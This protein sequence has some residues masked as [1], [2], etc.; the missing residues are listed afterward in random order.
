[1]W[2]W[3]NVATIVLGLS[4]GSFGVWSD[5][6]GVMGGSTDPDLKSFS[7]WANGKGYRLNYTQSRA[8]LFGV[9]KEA[10]LWRPSEDDFVDVLKL[11]IQKIT[12]IV[13]EILPA[14]R[15][16]ENE[17]QET[18]FKEMFK[19]AARNWGQSDNFHKVLRRRSHWL[20]IRRTFLD[21][22][23]LEVP[24]EPPD[25]LL[26]GSEGLDSEEE[27]EVPVRKKPR[28]NAS[29]ASSSTPRG[30]KR[31]S[32]ETPPEAKRNRTSNVSSGGR[33]SLWLTA[34]SSDWKVS[35][36]LGLQTLLF[37]YL[38]LHP[39]M[40]V[41]GGAFMFAA[42]GF[43]RTQSIEA[44]V[45]LHALAGGL[46]AM[47]LALGETLE[48]V[49]GNLLWVSL[50]G[51]FLFTCG[52]ALWE[53]SGFFAETSWS[54][55]LETHLAVGVLPA[56]PRQPLHLRLLPFRLPP[57]ALLLRR[58]LQPQK[59]TALPCL[60]PRLSFELKIVSVLLA[61]RTMLVGLGLQGLWVAARPRVAEVWA[62]MSCLPR[63]STTLEF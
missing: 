7:G 31:E 1:M 50:I 45:Q 9:R 36:W 27:L 2:H 39:P 34:T 32:S 21:E 63:R 54:G 30:I 60:L 43:V 44:S 18:F 15:S 42:Y 3:S 23:R 10:S 24:G 40:L 6:E 13:I 58:R 11:S 22:L 12:G 19:Q 29:S 35:A 49:M 17:D 5:S 41:S 48:D 26:F 52:P 28:L 57:H 33:F 47:S 16:V 37:G 20:V 14:L 61:V 25:D 59:K 56:C 4:L 51:L 53:S 8:L 38:G 55:L 46:F 62:P